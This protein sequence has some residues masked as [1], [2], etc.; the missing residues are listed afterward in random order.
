MVANTE[1]EF[2]NVLE[3]QS[4]KYKIDHGKM[5]KNNFLNESQEEISVSTNYF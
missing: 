4:T 5:N 1:E 2:K 3:V